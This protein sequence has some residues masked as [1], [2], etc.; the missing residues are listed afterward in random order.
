MRKVLSAIVLLTIASQLSYAGGHVRS[1]EDG[2]PQWRGPGRD[3][4]S[5][6]KGL[7]AAWPETGPK[8][9]WKVDGIG[10]GY[11]SPIINKGVIYVTGDAGDKLKITSLSLDGKSK[12]NVTNG[13][14]WQKS[15]PGARSSCTYSDGLLY[16]MN[17]HG[18]LV[19][20]E[21]ADGTEK[22]AVNIMTNYGTKNIMWG[23]SE[24]VLVVD[25]KIIVTPASSKALMVALDKKTGEE[26]WATEAIAGSQ[27]SYSSAI[28]VNHKRRRQVINVTSG[29]AFGVNAKNGKL[30]WKCAHHQKSQQILTSP[31]YTD[32][33]L[34]VPST[35]RGGA[36]SYCVKMGKNTGVFDWV[37]SAGDPSGSAVASDGQIVASN[38]H[39]PAGWVSYDPATGNVIASKL[40]LAYGAAVL[41]DGRYYC[42]THKGQV[43]LMQI[44]AD[45]FKVLS[46]FDFMTG[47]KN[48]WAHPVICDGKLYLRYDGELSCYDISGK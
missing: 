36:N 35:S 15:W 39:K 40:G 6:E 8:L 32:G 44:D 41:A 5:S 30:L 4:V 3:G 31:S 45:G 28:V 12:W 10:K 27:P 1:R 43:L 16:H 22:W 23:I 2:W 14:S 33:H 46:Q 37:V 25:D 21:P 19:C 7:L 48:V 42:L 11:S 34:F 47:K 20:L 17:A 9:L 24:S 26:M 29:H 18:R 13:K 38:S